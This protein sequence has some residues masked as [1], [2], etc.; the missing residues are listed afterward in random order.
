MVGHDVILRGLGQG[1]KH[2]PP[3]ILQRTDED[4]IGV[5]L[6]T[7][8]AED[9]YGA[10]AASQARARSKE[11]RLRLY[12]PVHRTFHVAL[13]DV[14]CD[15]PGLPRLDPAKIDSAGLV[16][17]RVDRDG[18]EP[19]EFPQAWLSAGKKLRGWSRMDDSDRDP[20]PERRHVVTAGAPEIGRRALLKARLE[21]GAE[22]VTDLFVAPPDVCQ[23]AGRTLLYGLIPTVSGEMSESPAPPISAGAFDPPPGGK[24]DLKDG[25]LPVYLKAGTGVSFGG[26]ASKF[27]TGRSAAQYFFFEDSDQAAAS[28]R[29]G[30]EGELSAAGQVFLGSETDQK[31]LDRFIDFLRFLRVSLD[32]WGDGPDS[33][34]LRQLVAQIL[35]PYTDQEDRDGGGRPADQVLL[36]ACTALVA[37]VPGAATVFQFPIRWPAVS[38]SLAD[39]I[40]AQVKTTLASR[41]SAL[42]PGVARFEDQTA[43]YQLRAFIRVKRDDGCPPDLVWSDVSEPFVI[44]PW[45]ENG[46]L[47]PVQIQLPDITSENVKSLLPN[48]AFKIPRRLFNF[49]NDNSPVDLLDGKG[50]EGLD[51]GLQ[52][53]CSFNISIIFV[54]AFIVMFIFLIILNIIFWW[55]PFIRICF[56]LPSFSKRSDS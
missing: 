54:L 30:Q 44:V 24:D 19:F 37:Q 5:L 49:L 28:L 10:V 22:E 21:D 41:L 20:E 7:L 18:L 43:V 33:R 14:A 40:Y 46:V 6:E 34:A 16:V 52:W 56:P 45:F 53:I 8:D 26:L 1:A 27:F 51:I 9:A 55:L 25:V 38:S 4:V 17:R 15:R 36:E 23:K 11:G 32:L 12:Q 2:G 48:V 31:R 39:R 35:L 42:Q 13:I 47:P 29:P 50:K 3:L